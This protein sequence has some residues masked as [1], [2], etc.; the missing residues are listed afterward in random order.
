VSNTVSIVDV[1]PQ[2]NSGE[3]G[4]NGE[5]SIA[6][7][8]ANP[9]QIIAGSFGGSGGNNTPYFVSTD[10][11]ATWSSFG[12]LGNEDKSIA[13]VAN[14]SAVLTATLV[15]PDEPLPLGADEEE[16]GSPLQL[17]T[18]S[19]SQSEVVTSGGNFGSAINNFVGSNNNDQPWLRI[20]PDGQVYMAYNDLGVKT[21]KTA[22]VNVST[23][24]GKSYPE[25]I[26]LDRVGGGPQDDPAIRLA[27]SNTTTYAIFDR[28]NTRIEHDVYGSRYDATL[29]VDKSLI[30]GADGFT[31]LGAG[32]DGTDVIDHTGVFTRAGDT[33]LSIGLNR[34]AGGDI[35]IAVDPNVVV[36]YIDGP[37]FDGAGVVQ[38]VVA[39][40]EDG[41]TTWTQKY[42][43]SDAARTSQPGLA[44]LADGT[45]GFLYDTF[46]PS[47]NEL[48]QHFITTS[49]DFASVHD[50]TLATE[51]NNTLSTGSPYL[52]DFFDL[53]SLGDTFYGIFSALNFDNG[54]RPS[55][56]LAVRAAPSF[57]GQN[58]WTRAARSAARPSSRAARSICHMGRWS[59]ATLRLP[60]TARS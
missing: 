50:I 53:T 3:T 21:G 27:V 18:Y 31:A 1:I 28:W 41:G 52:G 19:A 4:D 46:D 5:P 37:G 54:V 55:S 25:V 38:L 43:T 40:S 23:D 39:E 45:I 12:A 20:S 2:A 13:W 42:T 7:N 44:I 16:G 26:P 35:A 29:V 11:G 9:M 30:G 58:S 48:S 36:A 56:R 6:V 32:G 17:N 15:G 59:A 34:V 47:T 49:N 8:P 51:T 57:P 60:A 10:G 24:G 22:S 33:Q 14:G